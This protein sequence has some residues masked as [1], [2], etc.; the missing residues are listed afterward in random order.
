VGATEIEEDKKKKIR[1]LHFRYCGFIQGRE[2]NLAGK[3][4]IRRHIVIPLSLLGNV[5]KES[6]NAQEF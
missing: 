3:S 2:A 6:I 1:G 5:M 4:Q